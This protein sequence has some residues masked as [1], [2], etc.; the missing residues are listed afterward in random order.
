MVA[1]GKK[2]LRVAAKNVNFGIPYGRGSEAIARQ[3]KEEG[4]EVT[5]DE[6]QAMIDAYFESYPGTKD[7]LAACRARSQKPGWLVGPYGRLRRFAQVYSNDRA[8][9]GEQER[10]AQNFPIQGGV[11]DAV[12]LALANFVK[13]R[14]DHPEVNYRIALQIHDA[15][16]LVVPI[17]HAEFV[18]NE[19]IPKCMVDDVPFWP[20]KLDGTLIDV[21]A[22]YHF[23]MDRDVFVHWGEK[24]KP[25]HA[26]KLGLDWLFKA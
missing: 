1:A 3:C 6:C 9:I 26:K 5:A 15:I 14:A 24:L 23:G 4:V 11:A 18:Y 22:P 12:S 10:Q 21:P 20:R 2:G 17:E 13:Y 25:D 16:I 7:F 8:I 19:V